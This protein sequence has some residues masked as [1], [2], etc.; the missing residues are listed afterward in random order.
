MAAWQ[1][2]YPIDYSPSGDDI[3]TFSLKVK[4]EIA[5]LYELLDRLRTL[6]AS[7][8]TSTAD[9]VGHQWKIDTSTTPHTIYMYDGTAEAYIKMG[10]VA[11]NFGMNPSDIGGITGSGI[12]TLTMGKLEDRPANGHSKDIYIANDANTVYQYINGG[13]EVL[14]SLD[15]TKLL[16]V[17]SNLVLKNEVADADS[18]TEERVNK[19]PRLDD[20]GRGAF[21]ITGS[22]R[23]ISN[24]LIEIDDLSTGQAL[25]YNGATDTFQNKE[26]PMKNA[27]DVYEISITG[28]AGKVASKTILTNGTLEDG[29]ILVYR[30]SLNSFVNE[31][32][33]SAGAGKSLI[34]T[35]NGEQ[36]EYNGDIR[37][38]KDIS[39]LHY[40]MR[41]TA[42]AVGDIAYTSALPSYM[43]LECV[44]A[45]T[46][47]STEPDMSS[48][49]TGDTVTDG[50]AQFIARD[51]RIYSVLES[52]PVYYSR[53]SLMDGDQTTLTLPDVMNLNIGGKGY[54][55]AESIEI[56]ISDDSNWDNTI[57]DSPLER[58]GKNFY[59][60]A[61]Q[62]TTG[63][64][65]VFILSPNSTVPNGYNATNSR[66][67]G[68]FHCLCKDVGTISDNDLS[69]YV[70]GDILPT[71]V[72]DLKHR[73]KCGPEGML[74]HE[75][76]GVWYQIYLPSW[77]GEKLV[78]EYGGTIADGTSSPAFH[79]EKFAE[80]F[81][82]LGM[83]LIKRDEFIA[84]AKGSNEGTNIQG[85]ADPVTT[86]GH[87]DTAG[88][89]M[90]SSFGMEDAC[91]VLWQW[92][93]DCYEAMSTSWTSS[94]QHMNNYSWQTA[95]VY[96]SGTDP[97]QY[98]SCSGLLRRVLLGGAWDHGSHCGSRS[99]YCNLFSAYGGNASYGGR[100]AS[101][102]RV[103]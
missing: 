10:Y 101:E 33:G 99:A 29:Q 43:R 68:G 20:L 22:P 36:I 85:S 79:G 35:H 86:G 100:G 66:K 19:I 47:G 4:N 51:I 102:P 44:T 21:D 37:V 52:D 5:R 26:V 11:E 83:R 88:R 42:Y 67:I 27:S 8:G 13:W 6:D 80:E 70:A 78:S 55:L 98:G 75:G 72:W 81:G 32:K 57:Y 45:G 30:S 2:G 14:L 89:R 1:E 95:P 64:T 53:S 62:P 74:Y 59:V 25:I 7:A 3:D 28:N 48:V 87:V 16:N 40:L 90:I 65:P 103:A 49:E 61:C 41:D 82:K 77:D 17:Q 38:V 9:V 50:A 12:N 46:T 92:G 24:K 31:S 58:A 73:P 84:V 97:K 69:G 93:A 63:K 94:N 71:T 56:D 39:T 34:L 23:R 60:Y 91:G 96:H 76:T 54:T 15:F 18:T